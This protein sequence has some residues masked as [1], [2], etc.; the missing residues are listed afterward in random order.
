MTALPETVIE[1]VAFEAG[2]A[3]PPPV[4]PDRAAA[5][6]ATG[7]AGRRVAAPGETLLELT[8]RAA[9]KLP[10]AALAAATGLVAASFSREN[11]FPS[12]AAGAAK[13]LGLPPSAPAIDIQEACSAYPSALFVASMISAAR[14]GSVVVIDGDVQ[15][16]FVDP[17]DPGTAHIFSDA[18][19]VSLVR[20]MP[21]GGRKS[22]FASLSRPSDAL[23]CGPD[24]P[25]RMDGFGVF[26][27]VATEV[28]AFLAEFAAA[29]GGRDAIDFFVP[30]QA[31]MYM[32][33]RLARSLGLEDRM[34][35]TGG[36]WANPGSCSIPLTLV[37][38][39]R[40]G[41]HLLAGFGAGLS[42]SAAFVR[43][44]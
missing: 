10:R 29:C 27:F 38:K 28:S 21:G 7:L 8:L 35:E 20:S 19:T 9:A 2:S 15:S 30:H 5:I 39:G 23:S 33:R 43:L 11:R 42:A 34:L 1:A 22:L 26:S 37:A 24:G 36:E 41:R 40:P 25:V 3:A 16:P 44:L 32:V 14:G 4:P 17:A 13:A 12:F 31:N 18:S 6:A